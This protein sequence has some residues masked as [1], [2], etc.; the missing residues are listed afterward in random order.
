ML[1]SAKHRG[2]TVRDQ[3]QWVLSYY[4]SYGLVFSR[5]LRE[6]P[7]SALVLRR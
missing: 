7:W 2:M 4:R 1:R 5:A 3:E 6:G